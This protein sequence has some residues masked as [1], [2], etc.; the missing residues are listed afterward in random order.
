MQTAIAYMCVCEGWTQ[1]H[2]ALL[3]SVVLP[4]LVHPSVNSPVLIK[5]RTFLTGHHSCCLVPRSNVSGGEILGKLLRH[6]Q[7]GYVAES[8]F[9]RQLSQM[10]L[11]F[12][13]N[14]ERR[15]FR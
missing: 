7:V 12:N 10:G 8:S 3:K 6:N 5:R 4:L 2:P 13:P 14:L 9:S 15:P 1:I 11:F